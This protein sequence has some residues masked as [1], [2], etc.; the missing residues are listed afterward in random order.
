MII[1]YNGLMTMALLAVVLTKQLKINDYAKEDR[2]TYIPRHAKR[3]VNL[4]AE[5]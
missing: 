5:G 3:Y 1:D 4:Q 2:R